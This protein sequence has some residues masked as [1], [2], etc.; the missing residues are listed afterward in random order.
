M[1]LIF[2]IKQ[3]SHDNKVWH[4]FDFY[5]LQCSEERIIYYNPLTGARSGRTMTL[6]QKEKGEAFDLRYKVFNFKIM[7]F[8]PRMCYNMGKGGVYMPPTPKELSASYSY[9]DYLTWPEDER[10]E[11]IDGVP[12]NMTPAPTPKHQE[13]LGEL[14]RILANWLKGNRCR[15]YMAPF[16]VRLAGSDTLDTEIDKV[17]QPDISVV[18]DPQKIDDRGCLGAPDMIIEILSPST[19]KKDLGI[20]L[21]F[22]KVPGLKNI[23]SSTPW[24]K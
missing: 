23:G 22:M 15:A 2:K 20:K 21:T 6:P 10:W 8:M 5:P 17:V 18:C 7:I 4:L 9:A 24:M 1:N 16:D 12:F 14:F 13:I 11:L 19:F 3:M